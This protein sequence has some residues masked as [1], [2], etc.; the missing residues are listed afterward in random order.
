VVLEALPRLL[1]ALAERSLSAVC[2]PRPG[3]TA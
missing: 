2:V 3:A 1:D